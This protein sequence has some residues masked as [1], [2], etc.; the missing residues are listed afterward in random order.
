AAFVSLERDI[1]CFLGVRMRGEI[2]K[3][4]VGAVLTTALLLAAAVFI[5][6]AWAGD[7][8]VK[9]DGSSKTSS[10]TALQVSAKSHDS[11]KVDVKAHESTKVHV[12]SKSHVSSHVKTHLSSKA[13][14]HVSSK[15]HVSSH[16]KTHLSSKAK[17]HVS[18]KSHVSS[19]VKTHLS[20]KAK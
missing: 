6:T 7:G 13:K 12:S 8:K 1:P 3:K 15:S 11:A 16:V 18:S 9:A 2:M 4:S 10:K 20:S 5:G 14:V 17:V 19:H